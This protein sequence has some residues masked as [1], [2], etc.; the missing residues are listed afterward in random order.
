ML[1]YRGIYFIYNIY[2]YIN[3]RVYQNIPDWRCKN[4]K[5]HHKRVWK[6]PTSTQLRATWRTDSLDIV[7]LPSNVASRYRNWCVDDG[8]SPEYMDTHSYMG[9]DRSVIIANRYGLDGPGIKSRCGRDYSHPSRLALGPT[10]PPV[11]WVPGLFLGYNIRGRRW[12]PNPSS[13]RLRKE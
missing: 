8:T 10:Q 11:Q 4:H 7:V 1:V 12:S 9:R 3:T 6:L 13:A 5:P 2:I